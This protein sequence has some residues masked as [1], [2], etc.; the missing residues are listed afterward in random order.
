MILIALG[1]N[2]PSIYGDPEATLYKSLEILRGQGIGILSCSS[3]WLS[4][5]VPLSDQP[6]YRNAVVSVETSLSPVMLMNVLHGVEEAFGRVREERNAP[7]VLDLDLIAYHDFVLSERGV[8]V[9]HPRAHERAFV[10]KPLAEIAK[11][12]V[13]PVLHLSVDE[14]ILR[15]SP[16][17]ELVRADR[18]VA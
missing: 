4:A 9:P 17:Q 14:L 6:W 10:L 5:P 3:I 15:L 11:T 16:A 13:H 1:A 2:L 7:R 12:W 18:L 8:V